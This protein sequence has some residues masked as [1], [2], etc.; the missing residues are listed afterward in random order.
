MSNSSSAKLFISYSHSDKTFKD[1]LVK[2]LEPLKVNGVFS[3]YFVDDKIPVGGHIDE[4]LALELA[5]YDFILF[6]VSPDFLSSPYCV[7]VELKDAMFRL[8]ESNVQ[9]I[10]IVIKPCLLE[11]STLGRYK[12]IPEDAV[13]VTEHKDSNAAWVSVVRALVDEIKL[14]DKKKLENPSSNLTKWVP[15]KLGGGGQVQDD[16]LCF[17]KSTE[18]KYLHGHK[19]DVELS[20]VYVYP[21]VEILQ[22]KLGDAEMVRSAEILVKNKCEKLLLFGQEQSGKTSFAKMLVRK[23]L[24]DDILTLYVEAKKIKRS[25][26]ER[27]LRQAVK[28]QYGFESYSDFLASPNKKSVV[29]DDYTEI[30][31]N[32]SHQE[33]LLENLTCDFDFIIILSDEPLKH[34]E[35]E[36]VLFSEYEKYEIMPFGHILRDRIV[37]KWCSLGQEETI[38][39]SDLLAQIDASTVHLNSMLRKNIVPSKPLFILT[40]LQTLQ[41]KISSDYSL[42]S[43][44]YCYQFLIQ[45]SLTKVDIKNHEI[46][47]YINYMSELAYFIY[48]SGKFSVGDNKFNEFKLEYSKNYMIDESHESVISKL[49]EAG[50]LKFDGENLLFCYKY[51]FYFYSA[52]YIADN[53]KDKVIRLTIETLCEKLHLEKNA[54]IL[55]FITHH[56]KDT[57]VIDEIRLHASAIFEEFSE[58]DLGDEDLAHLKE[59]LED[60]PAISLE[61]TSV[62]E[63]REKQL[64][65]KDEAEKLSDVDVDEEDIFDNSESGKLIANVIR[66]SKS[67]EI[68]GQILRNRCGSMRRDDLYELSLDAHAAGLR[69]LKFYF[70]LTELH[71]DEVVDVIKKVLTKKGLLDQAKVERYARKMLLQICYTIA[72]SVVKQISSCTGSVKLLPIFNDISKEKNTPAHRLINL[73]VHLEFKKEIPKAMIS[74]MSKDFEGNILCQ[75]MLHEIVVQHLYMHY[76]NYHDKQWIKEVLGFSSEL[77]NGVDFQKSKKKLAK[78]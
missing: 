64:K 67:V 3:D 7:D 65:N 58:A 18:I 26:L 25:N 21:D 63:V 56:T 62:D 28:H 38:S 34:S 35:Y 71:K 48:A 59:E 24:D 36:Y 73:S 74:S 42:T 53:I 72:L 43:H 52:K 49:T 14:F 40:I 2:H 19:E 50:I 11:H 33:N 45:Q 23:G 75:R 51:I 55:I 17:L 68:I 9:I 31:L 66:S 69:F 76:V 5:K 37:K 57:N 4:S 10:P 6:L 41:S 46:D 20:D 12:C 13:P 32:E 78:V 39:Q 44:G 47:G 30:G 29:I 8:V 16:F 22:E 1:E 60:I 77:T 70:S 54:N 15:D 61:S 27:T